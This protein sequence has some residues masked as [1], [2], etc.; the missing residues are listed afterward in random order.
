VTDEDDGG[1]IYLSGSHLPNVG[2]VPDDVLSF[3]RDREDAAPRP[4]GVRNQVVD[5]EGSL[6]RREQMRC[7]E[8]AVVFFSEALIHSGM[9]VLSE[10]TR[11]AMFNDFTV[12]WMKGTD[13]SNRAPLSSTVERLE[14]GELRDILGHVHIDDRGYVGQWNAS[15]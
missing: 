14:E 4:S 2:D 8:G 11:Y 6:A 5:W 9:A 1:T 13:V 15:L 10:R 3:G 12:P 7:G